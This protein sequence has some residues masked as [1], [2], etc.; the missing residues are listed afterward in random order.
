[1][2]HTHTC[3]HTH[4][5]AFVEFH[6]SRW[7]VHPTHMYMWSSC[8]FDVSRSSWWLEYSRG[9]WHCDK[10]RGSWHFDD[11]WSWWNSFWLGVRDMWRTLSYVEITWVRDVEDV[12]HTQLTMTMCVHISCAHIFF[13]DVEDSVICWDYVSSWCWRC[14]VD[15]V[16]T[17][18][19]CTHIL[20]RCG[21]RTQE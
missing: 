11:S 12:A 19:M 8:H 1:M 17:Y 6:T 18:I 21:T 14:G 20:W 2:T 13:E 4:T 15:D 7:L 10:S 5:C 9:S 16:C 3:P